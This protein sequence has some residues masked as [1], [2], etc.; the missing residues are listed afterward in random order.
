MLKISGDG[1]RAALDLR[2]AGLP[3]DTPGKID[4]AAGR[5]AVIWEAHRDHQYTAP[6]GRPYPVRGALQLVFC[7]LGTPGPGWNAY[8]ELRGQLAA[9]GVPRE[10]IRFIHEAK[11]RPGQGAAVRRVPERQ[12][13]CSHRLDRENGRRHQRPGPRDRTAPSGRALAPGR[14]RPAR[15]PHRPP[16]NLNPEV[17]VLRYVTEGSFDGYMWQTLERKARFIG[18]VMRGKL[19]A[20]EIGDIG[21]TALSF[22]EVKA[23]AT[24]NPLLMDKAEADVAVARLQRAE[25]AHHRNQDALRHAVAHYEQDITIL[26]RQAAEVDAAIARRRDTRGDR[27]AMTVGEREHHKRAEAGQHLKEILQEEVTALSGQRERRLVAGQ[28]GGSR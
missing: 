11:N 3:Q 23:L 7:D 24:G 20:R 26:N 9:R 28:L 6:D 4:A 14:R 13:R 15:W 12:R 1:R 2:L 16:G 19:D 18:Q 27:F 22:S 17:Q 25:R 21:D 8:D 5:I 10:A